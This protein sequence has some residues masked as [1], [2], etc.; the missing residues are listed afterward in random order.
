MSFLV[1][2][3][4]AVQYACVAFA[5]WFIGVFAYVAILS[6]NYPFHLEWMEGHTVDIILRLREGLPFYTKPTLE[7]VP[8]IYTPYYFYV[9]TFV[10]FFTGVDF[11]AGR[12]VSLLSTFCLVWLLYAWMR[13]E[14][15]D[16]LLSWVAAGLYLSTYVLSARWF[17]V[18]RVDSL[19]LLLMASGLYVFYF[20]RS[21]YVGLVSGCI[22]AAAFFTKQSALLALIPCFLAALYIRPRAALIAGSVTAVIILV[23]CLLLEYNSNAWFSFFVYHVPAGHVN[24]GRKILTFWTEDLIPHC[25]MM[26]VVAVFGWLSTYKNGHKALLWYASIA[27]GFI[28]S[29]YLSRIHSYGH[30]NVIM[31]AHFA[32]ALLSGLLLMHSAGKYKIINIVACFALIYQFYS[33]I[34]DPQRFV[35]NQDAI[36]RGN[37]LLEEIRNIEGEVLVSE[38]QY[39]Q[40]RVGKKTYTV[41][42]AGFDLM[43]A[44]LKGRNQVKTEYVQSIANAIKNKKFSAIV[45]GYFIRLGELRGHYQ[46]L[47]TIDNPQEFVTGGVYF[48]KARIFVPRLDK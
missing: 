38:L 25:A 3:N 12:L 13:K 43:R 5:F 41:G 30:S 16:K 40:P 31:P 4:R 21:K 22:F 6:V 45:V 37:A 42:M 24:D 7:Y 14:G 32:L 39:V 36:A 29:A 27:L 1:Y 35:P 34:Y 10:S 48:N 17:D 33:L 19:Y 18:A 23:G 26:V 8:Y 11:L 20:D 9:A 2:T 15:G 46:L 44:D 28:G 47:K